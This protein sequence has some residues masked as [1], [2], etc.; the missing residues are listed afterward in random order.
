M[1][2]SEAIQKTS[3]TL[4]GMKKQDVIRVLMVAQQLNIWRKQQ[5]DMVINGLL[6]ADDEDT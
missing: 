6:E 4:R 5:R 3:D 1:T 2:K